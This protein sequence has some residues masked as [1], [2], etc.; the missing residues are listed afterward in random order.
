VVFISDVVYKNII[1]YCCTESIFS[2]T[3]Y[4]Y[5]K[6]PDMVAISSVI[7]ASCSPEL[8]FIFSS[9]IDK[10]GPTPGVGVVAFYFIVVSY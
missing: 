1:S 7:L 3:G 8:P 2:I 4:Y 5:I 6:S 10:V 9:F